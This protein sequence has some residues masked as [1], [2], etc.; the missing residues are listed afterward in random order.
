MARRTVIEAPIAFSGRARHGTRTGYVQ[1]C[2]CEPCVVAN[3]EWKRG[4]RGQRPLDEYLADLEARREKHG[5]NA[6]GRGCRC[7]VCTQANTEKCRPY[8]RESNRRRLG[9]KMDDPV[10]CPEC[11]V[12][13]ADK[14][15]LRIHT[16]RIHR[17]TQP[18]DE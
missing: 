6:Y 8:V 14:R 10:P 1:G 16:A 2:R 7:D 4:W 5:L 18:G 13:L 11:G 15:G 9:I 3:R 17:S 12:E